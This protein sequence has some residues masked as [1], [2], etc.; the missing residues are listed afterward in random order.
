MDC[1]AVNIERRGL[2]LADCELVSE[3]RFLSFL[4]TDLTM[5]TLRCKA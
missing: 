1:V 3:E 5:V 2:E 4:S